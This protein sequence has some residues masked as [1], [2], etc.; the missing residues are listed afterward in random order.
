[1]SKPIHS[2]CTVVS[3]DIRDPRSKAGQDLWKFAEDILPAKEIG[4]FNLALMDIGSLVWQPLEP[5]CEKCPLPLD[6][7]GLC[8][9]IAGSDTRKATKPEITYTVDAAIVLWQD[10]D[11]LSGNTRVTNVGRGYGISLDSQSIIH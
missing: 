9:T 4:H 11:W 1:M 7:R 5:N 6:C 8:T 3:W 10:E 2:G